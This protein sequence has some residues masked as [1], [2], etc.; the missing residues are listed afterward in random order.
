LLAPA[1]SRSC[2]MSKSRFA[3]APFVDGVTLRRVDRADGLFGEPDPH[4][5]NHRATSHD[6]QRPPP[7]EA[8]PVPRYASWPRSPRRVIGGERSGCPDAAHGGER[9]QAPLPQNRAR[10]RPESPGVWYAPAS[11]DAITMRR[12]RW[13]RDYQ[14]IE[15]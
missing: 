13:P 9:R 11:V 8:R 5:T 6:T 4:A 15:R 12:E 2:R 3:F 10:P 14:F 1:H 7:S